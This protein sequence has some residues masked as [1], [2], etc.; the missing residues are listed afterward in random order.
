MPEPVNHCREAIRLDP[1]MLQAPILAMG[2]ALSAQGKS[3]EALRYYAEG[4]RLGIPGLAHGSITTSGS[5]W[6]KRGEFSTRRSRA[7]V[8]RCAWR[9]TW[10]EARGL[11]EHATKDRATSQAIAAHREALRVNPELPEA[12]NNLAWIL[13]THPEPQFRNGVEAVQLAGQACER[14]A[15][16]QALFV[17]TL[18][19]A[20]AEAGQFDQAVATAEKACALASALGQTNL[21]TRNQQ[22]LR[23]YQNRQ[24]CREANG[25]QSGVME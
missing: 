22:L 10:A 11:L 14:T 9:P 20:Y 25:A 2:R 16:K 21:L 8:R 3:D 7:S 19:A 23:L 13:A 4:L 24:P 15:W 17:G 1:D 12:L 6:M 18:A 5:E